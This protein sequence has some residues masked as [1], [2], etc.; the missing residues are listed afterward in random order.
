MIE[1][2]RRFVEPI[3]DLIAEHTGWKVTL[4]AGGPEPADGGHLNIVRS[5][6][7]LFSTLFFADNITF[8]W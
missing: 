5:V 3:L 6:F 8:L 4:I 2:L 1:S 7:C